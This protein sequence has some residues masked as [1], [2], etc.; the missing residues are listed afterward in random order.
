MFL[1]TF[2]CNETNIHKQFEVKNTAE[3]KFYGTRISELLVWL[4]L[5][6]IFII[7]LAFDE[8]FLAE[9]VGNLGWNCRKKNHF[10]TKLLIQHYLRHHNL[11]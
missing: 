2:I 9:T 4:I 7:D 8:R 3:D 11:V 5:K 1:R 10:Y 6:A